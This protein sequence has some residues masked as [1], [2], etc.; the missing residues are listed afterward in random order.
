MITFYFYSSIDQVP[1]K[2]TYLMLIFPLATRNHPKSNADDQLVYFITY[3]VS[4][5][6]MIWN[7]SLRI[8][9]FLA[10]LALRRI[11]DNLYCLQDPCNSNYFSKP[12]RLS[13]VPSKA[14]LKLDTCM[15]FFSV[16][17]HLSEIICEFHLKS[18]SSVVIILH[19]QNVKRA[20][21][22]THNQST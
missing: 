6:F 19:P 18:F 9:F 17:S 11:M 22:E 16:L 8:L 10:L 4:E 20:D 3:F 5:C 12:V 21:F 15:V 7:C 2:H 14:I 13:S 1:C